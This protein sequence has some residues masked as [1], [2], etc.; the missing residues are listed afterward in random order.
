MI[1]Q[2]K[3]TIFDNQAAPEPTGGVAQRAGT[4][5]EHSVAN[6]LFS[7]G[8]PGI[9]RADLDPGILD[10][11]N[12]PVHIFSVSAAVAFLFLFVCFLLKSL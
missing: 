6:E 10:K 1:I 9:D 7:K 3:S 12:S 2:S 5:Q 4:E 8:N 11:V